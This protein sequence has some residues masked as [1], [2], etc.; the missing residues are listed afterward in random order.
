MLGYYVF[1]YTLLYCVMD[2]CN[3]CLLYNLYLW[4]ILIY[5]IYIYITVGNADLI[6]GSKYYTSHN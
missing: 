3:V 6:V 4:V 1:C 2:I 5:Y